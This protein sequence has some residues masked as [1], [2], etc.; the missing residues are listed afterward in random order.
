MSESHARRSDELGRESKN[1]GMKSQKRQEMG[2]TEEKR[3]RK[4]MR[5][6]SEKHACPR[7]GIHMALEMRLGRRQPEKSREGLWHPEERNER[8]ARRRDPGIAREPL[9][10]R[11]TI[12]CPL[13]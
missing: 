10:K 9:G 4:T 12:P 13:C 1:R 5:V 7:R 11:E 6:S 3:A 8:L 2:E